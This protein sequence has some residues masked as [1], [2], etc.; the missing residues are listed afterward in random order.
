L[1]RSR[2]AVFLL[3]S[4]VGVLRR[5]LTTKQFYRVC[6]AFRESVDP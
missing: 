3:S 4:T 6:P 2:I 1:L 5:A